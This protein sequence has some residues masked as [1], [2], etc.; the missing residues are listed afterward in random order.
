M[1]MTL[2]L[3]EIC[4]DD[5]TIVCRN[6]EGV[7]VKFSFEFIRTVNNMISQK[8]PFPVLPLKKDEIV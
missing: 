2:R 6:A 7:E 4:Y 3:D 5:A 1:T 8:I